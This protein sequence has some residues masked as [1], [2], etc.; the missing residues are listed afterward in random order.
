MAK[1]ELHPSTGNVFEDLGIADSEERH[2]KALLSRLIDKTIAD[3][4]LTQGE[5]AEIL[6]CSQPDVSNIVRGQVAGFTMDRL[7]RFLVRLGYSVEIR[8]VETES[9]KDAHLL[10]TS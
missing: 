7:T 4:R 1:I 2:A 8:V 6:G 9:P 3:R 5:A 10:V